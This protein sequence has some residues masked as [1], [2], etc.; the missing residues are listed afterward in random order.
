MNNNFLLDLKKTGYKLTAP[1]KEVL[2]TL[3]HHVPQSAQEVSTILKQKGFNIDLVTVYRTLELFQ[4]I[5]IAN[6]IQFEDK[7]ARYE[8]VSDKNHHHHLVCVKCQRIAKFKADETALFNKIHKS[9]NFQA[10]RH[11]L[12]FF[13]LCGRCQKP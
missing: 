2:R 6:K 1:R 3:S 9:T 12:E 5:G 13:G 10:M 8:L 4:T 7:T 11:S